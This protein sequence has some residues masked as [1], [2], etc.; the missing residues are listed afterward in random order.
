MMCSNASCTLF[1]EYGKCTVMAFYLA[2]KH[3]SVSRAERKPFRIKYSH[4]FGFQKKRDIAC[5]M[6]VHHS[7]AAWDDH[8]ISMVDS[9]ASILSVP[10]LYIVK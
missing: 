5:A 8:L 4:E 6:I 2:L 10:H 3:L 1:R 7:V 9:R